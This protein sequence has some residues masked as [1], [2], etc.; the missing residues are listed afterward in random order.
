MTKTSFALVGLIGVGLVAGRAHAAPGAPGPTPAPTGVP[1]PIVPPVTD[2]AHKA[3]DQ[4]AKGPNANHLVDSQTAAYAATPCGY[5][6]GDVSWTMEHP[7]PKVTFQVMLT[8]TPEDQAWANQSK[9]NCESLEGTLHVLV[10]G[11][12][13]TATS[14]RGRWIK[15]SNNVWTCD[16]AS[17]KTAPVPFK[18][19]F[20]LL[21]K[22]T[23]NGAP[24]RVGGY[25][26][27]SIYQSPS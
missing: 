1:V 14:G 4:V 20:R 6:V 12:G 25:A 19:K 21:L 2:C 27:M 26:N 22:V 16:L 9:A 10:D 15:S 23:K 18:K 11:E 5:F 3:P 7:L 8:R 13:Y 24:A 17:V